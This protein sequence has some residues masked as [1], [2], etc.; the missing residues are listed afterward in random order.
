MVLLIV[1]GIIGLASAGMLVYFGIPLA[2]AL[3]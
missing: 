3:L 1:V 2:L